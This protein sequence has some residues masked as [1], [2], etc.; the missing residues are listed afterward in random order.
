MDKPGALQ[1]VEELFPAPT[2]GIRGELRGKPTKSTK[3][4]SA[5]YNIDKLSNKFKKFK[6]SHI[7]L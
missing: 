3:K 1:K 2:G 5:K 4:Y 7:F 6:S